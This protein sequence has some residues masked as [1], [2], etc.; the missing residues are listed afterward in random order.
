MNFGRYFHIFFLINFILNSCDLFPRLKLSK[1]VII[2]SVQKVAA[3]YEK[4]NK[5]KIIKL[6]MTIKIKWEC[7][8]WL[9]IK[10]FTSCG[11]III[12]FKN[13]FFSYLL[14]RVNPINDLL[15]IDIYQF[16]PT[17]NFTI[18]DISRLLSFDNF[19]SHFSILP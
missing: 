7:Y 3:N 4:E 16:L 13:N 6:L 8:S 14:V 12:V 2:I 18:D 11:T 15:N 9:I 10:F 5:E 1:V 17:F 19:H